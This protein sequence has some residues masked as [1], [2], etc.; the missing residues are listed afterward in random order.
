MKTNLLDKALFLLLARM[1]ALS[2]AACGDDDNENGTDDPDALV[3]DQ[4]EY[5]Q[6]SLVRVDDA[7]NFMY[8]VCGAPL[9]ADTTVLYVGVDNLEEA[10]TLFKQLF[11]P[12]STFNESGDNISCT[13]EKK[14][15]TVTF[16]PADGSNGV[17]ADVTF[18]GCNLVAVSSLHFMEKNAWP[19]NSGSAYKVGDRIWKQTLMYGE[20]CWICLREAGNGQRGVLY[21]LGDRSVSANEYKP[22]V[23]T[24]Y[25]TDS[26]VAQVLQL[27]D[28]SGVW[29]G[30]KYYSTRSYSLYVA[31]QKGLR[32]PVL[33]FSFFNETDALD[34]AMVGDY[35]MN[36]GTV[37]N[38][39]I[40]LTAAEKEACIGIVVW[41]GNPTEYDK[42]LKKL[43][44][45]CTHGL[46]AAKYDARYGEGIIWSNADIE[47]GTDMNAGFANTYKFRTCNIDKNTFIYAVDAVDNYPYNT[48]ES[49]FAPSCSS[50]WYIAAMTECE[51]M[52]EGEK[53]W[54][55]QFEKIG[56]SLEH[57]FW[58]STELDD[59]RMYI[60]WGVQGIKRTTSK[61]HPVLAF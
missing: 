52:K 25:P 40:T 48:D 38:G 16:A 13:L 47:I 44:P 23:P 46:V 39:D 57:G 22:Y 61:V 24:T 29:C 12:G 15:G 33:E 53:I 49:L 5:L 56:G 18:D 11:V 34:L 1:T 6:N 14:G 55:A 3:M 50:G 8:R 60:A 27:L 59:G 30:Y 58:S 9:D 36:D 43:H 21:Y 32:G 35:Y 28:K 10:K 7:G 37:K 19:E 20:Q 17:L 42:Q 41:K 51:T 54:K 45:H 26:E 2:F 4:K 31:Q